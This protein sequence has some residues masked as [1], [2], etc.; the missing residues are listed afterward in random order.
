MII[1]PITLGQASLPAPAGALYLA[2]KAVISAPELIIPRRQPTGTVL[3]NKR[4]KYSDHLVGMWPMWQGTPEWVPDLVNGNIANAT[5][6]DTKRAYGPGGRGLSYTD[7]GTGYLSLGSIDSTNPLSCSANNE[8]TVITRMW[9]PSVIGS[10]FPRVL[11]KT[12]S[13]TAGTGGYSFNFR[14][15]GAANPNNTMACGIAGTNVNGADD[16][17][18]TANTDWTG[19]DAS[20]CWAWASGD[21]DFYFKH[22][23]APVTSSA[24]AATIPTTTAT[25]S[26]ISMNTSGDRGWLGAVYII[27]VWDIK[28]P[29]E[30]IEALMADPYLLL[31]SP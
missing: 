19:F 4:H 2:D 20:C 23:I 31:E 30:W 8:M 22:G 11:D 17:L 1:A 24:T 14:T 13:A 6:T 29:Q 7:N 3:W 12:T 25:A 27:M 18:G 26:L 16:A 15:Q 5:N 28:I 9:M 21:T 10:S